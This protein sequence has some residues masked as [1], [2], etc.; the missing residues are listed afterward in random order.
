MVE[1]VN[2][3]GRDDIVGFFSG[4]VDVALSKGRTFEPVSTWS[5]EFGYSGWR[6]GTNPRFLKD[7]NGDKLPDIV[8]FG[9]TNV[10][11]AINTGSSFAKSAV[12]ISDYTPGKG[13]STEH[14]RRL[15][16]MNGDGL[17]DIVGFGKNGVCISL[18]T[19]TSF[20]PSSPQLK[21]FGYYSSPAYRVAYHER[22]VADMTGDGLPDLVGF[23]S[24]G[25]HV[26]YNRGNGT[27]S[28]SALWV[29]EFGYSKGWRMTSY[30]RYLLD[31]NGDGISDI[32]GF[33]NDGVYISLNK[34]SH[35][36]IHKVVDSFNNTQSITYMSLPMALKLG[37]YEKSYDVKYP[38]LSPVP[39]INIVTKLTQ[40]E[41]SEAENTTRYIFGNFRFDASGRGSQGF[42][43][44]KAVDHRNRR[45]ITEYEQAFPFTG[46]TKKIQQNVS[47][48]TGDDITISE[49]VTTYESTSHLSV[50][51]IMPT[52]DIVTS[53]E[54]SGNQVSEIETTYTGSNG[55]GDALHTTSRTTGGGQTFIK[56]TINIYRDLSDTWLVGQ[57][58]SSKVTQESPCIDPITRHAIYEYDAATGY[59][60]SQTV[61][62]DH[63]LSLKTDFK[64]D[65]FGNVITKTET[66]VQ[67]IGKSRLI[68]TTFDKNGIL[69]LSSSNGVGHTE[70]YHYDDSGNL[71]TLTG[72]NGLNTTWTYDKLGRKVSEHQADGTDITWSYN[73]DQTTAGAVYNIQIK[74]EGSPTKTRVFDLL[75]RVIHEKSVGFDNSDIFED[76]TYNKE[77]L[78]YRH[79]YPHFTSSHAAWKVFYYDDLGRTIRKETPGAGGISAEQHL[80]YNGLQSTN[81]NALGHSTHLERDVLGQL[82][83]VTDHL[84]G[85]VKYKYDA[86]GNMIEMTDTDGHVTSTE[87]NLLGHKTQ[88]ND[89]NM[90]LWKY[91]H[92]AFGELIWQR[93][94]KQNVLTQQYDALGRLVRRN[95]LEGTTKWIYDTRPNGLGK[96]G[97]VQGPD[98]YSKS[99]Y[100]DE[101]GKETKMITNFQ[102]QEYKISTEYDS[103]GR[104]GKQQYPNGQS[105]YKMY[106]NNG[107]LLEVGLGESNVSPSSKSV[108]KALEYDALGR[109]QKEH[110]GNDLITDY[111]Y[112]SAAHMVGITTHKDGED[113]VRHLN[114]IYDLNEN[115]LSRRDIAQGVSESFAY[116]E[117]DRLVQSTVVS[118]DEKYH[119]RQNWDYYANG[120]IR[121]NDAYGLDQFQYHKNK[122]HAVVKAGNHTYSYDA[123][124]NAV[125][126]DGQAIH[127][128]S[129]NKPSRFDAGTGHT[130]FKYGPDRRRYT[131]LS[132]NGDSTFY[133]GK[134]YEIHTENN[135]SITKIFVYGAMGRLVAI[136][137]KPLT[138][139]STNS[140]SYIH[141]DNLG[142]VDTISHD[143]SKVVE[144]LSYDA[145]GMRRSDDWMYGDIKSDYSVRG[146]TGHEHI[147]ELGLIHMNG[148]VYDPQVGRFLSPD[149]HVQD[150]ANTQCLNRYSYA[151]NNPL[152]YNDP[153]G[154][155]WGKL[156]R[157]IAGAVL[158]VVTFGA[159][160]PVAAAAV[161]GV[162][163]TGAAATVA[164]GAIAGAASGFVGGTVSTGSV[165]GGLK[166]AVGGA[167]FGGISGHFGSTWNLQRVATQATAGGAVSEL[168]GG[169]FKD[170]FAMAGLAASARYLYNSVVQYDIDPSAG[171]P[172]SAKTINQRPVAGANNIGIQGKP[173]DPSWIDKDMFLGINWGEGG[174]VSRALNRI[175]GVN[176][177]SGLHDIFQVE[178]DNVLFPGARDWFNVPGMLP[179]SVISYTALLDGPGMPA[180]LMDETR[181]DKR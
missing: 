136:V 58:M 23:Y 92:N 161:A 111:E 75:D 88:S 45:I 121:F 83:K 5:R 60:T 119:R 86:I 82:I 44:R 157:A 76:I 135:L 18:S 30:P 117:L 100:F 162:G 29:S 114:Y 156:F 85:I 137:S 130:V 56:R 74:S 170:G 139:N 134:A 46:N 138:A 12:W 168:G 165:K 112:D 148:R 71:E 3:D 152:K 16:D 4:R 42:Q 35:P 155:F 15:E 149:P 98:G 72:A 108:W 17:A 57:L 84:G 145:F 120:N 166:A 127:W 89:P 43:W 171:G 99:W 128:T 36:K 113:T 55:Y 177:V 103:Y 66:P 38:N 27:F 20:T 2:G 64:Y 13:W 159:F 68:I 129:Y 53:Y 95:E 79:S 78:V 77:G 8:G 81:I 7:V 147:P 31:T 14:P 50:H 65:H 173:P 141:T 93:D 150:P 167:V 107:Y 123:N 80:S 132:A 142:S 49:T 41:D 28:S 52:R 109:M 180:L 21:E 48:E 54:L 63:E 151:L 169:K 47:S 122:P 59:V 176:A 69:M 115:L 33:K 164:S 181:K 146:Y 67:D 11:V 104:I 73:W 70:K 96:L 19:G 106:T 94:A 10:Y 125:T 158:A 87:Y 133:L 131:K 22:L 118:D 178:M 62:P 144:R 25:V 34:N 105:V 175:P 61:E 26:S 51:D 102:G 174:G 39:S 9:S 163:L 160:L 40:N 153:T 90:G 154:F 126:K 1:D 6:V 110:Y 101:H 143:N 24:D 116:D 172:A 97:K 140:L 124:G 179:A 37:H 91:K 32:V